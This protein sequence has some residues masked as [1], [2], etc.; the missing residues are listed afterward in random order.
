MGIILALTIV[1]AVIVALRTNPTL[2]SGNQGASN[3]E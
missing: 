3:D 1:V 2:F